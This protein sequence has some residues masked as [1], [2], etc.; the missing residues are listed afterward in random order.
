MP[1]EPCAA[2]ASTRPGLHVLAKPIGPLCNLA[3]EYC[4]YLDKKTLYGEKHRFRMPDAVLERFIE[5]YLAASPDPEV[6]FAWQGGEPTL[7]GL[8]FFERVV[9]LQRKHCPPERRVTNAL[10]TNG[11]LLDDAWCEFLRREEFLVGL[12]IDGPP[13]LHDRYRVDQ[14]GAPTF[15]RVMRALGLLQRHGVEFNTLT[16]VH[17]ENSQEPLETYRFLKEQGSRFVQLIPLVERCSPDGSL[18]GPP[19]LHPGAHPRASAA[20][21]TDWSVRPEDYG[22]FL[23]AIFDEWVRRDVGRIY[24][25]LFELQVAIRLGLPA[26]L[27]LF[28][29]TCG[30]NLALEHNGDV[31]ACDH[32]VYP[33]YLRGNIRDRS[34]A[35]WA[36]AAAQRGFGRMKRD[37]LPRLCRECDV[38]FACHGECP[39][40]RFVM[41]RDGEPGLNYLCPAYQRFLRHVDPQARAIADLLRRGQPAALIME[42]L[43]PRESARPGPGVRVGRND[44]CPC[45][46]G[47]KYKRCCAPGSRAH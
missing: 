8:D 26:S 46:S 39:K 10:Q 24:V 12:S 35:D 47:R 13:H 6:N 25:Q 1:I 27:C 32:Y 38:R 7:M 22:S 14:G 3:C 4:F 5:Q 41:T 42:P 37:G 44:P 43:A 40:H 9:E 30:R 23:C 36:G 20:E 33:Q 2:T 34:L 21:V 18:A 16:V 15:D 45:G 28:A 29:P 17:R 19:H 31:Y 11:L